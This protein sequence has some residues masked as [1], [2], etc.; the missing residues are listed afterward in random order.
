[1]FAIHHDSPGEVGS[2]SEELGAHRSR[3]ESDGTLLFCS[4]ITYSFCSRWSLSETTKVRNGNH[5]I[6]SGKRFLI[7]LLGF[8][9][10]FV[11]AQP[12]LCALLGMMRK[13]QEENMHEEFLE[14]W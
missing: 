13:L 10:L 12:M 3:T 5:F 2:S 8:P 6:V 11:A 9:I 1:M 14:K 4:D 7:I